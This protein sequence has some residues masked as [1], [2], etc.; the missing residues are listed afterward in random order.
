MTE[1]SAAEAG[2]SGGAGADSWTGAGSGVV[3]WTGASAGGV[4]EQCVAQ[5]HRM[6]TAIT[7]STEDKGT[8]SVTA[9]AETFGIEI[10][11]AKI[12]S[13]KLEINPKCLWNAGVSSNATFMMRNKGVVSVIAEDCEKN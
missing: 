7:K 3:L 11:L 9:S 8:T 1:G 5:I 13:T 12:R 6:A 10:A 4:V 2:T